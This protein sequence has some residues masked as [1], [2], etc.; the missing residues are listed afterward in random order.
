M[1]PAAAAGDRVSQSGGMW[2]AVLVAALVAFPVVAQEA[3]APARPEVPPETSLKPQ[4]RPADRAGT[5]D[6]DEPGRD[7]PLAA[8]QALAPETPPKPDR[9]AMGTAELAACL[10]ALDLLGVQYQTIAPIS[11]P[12]DAACG[13][14]QP[15]EVSALPGGVALEPAGQMR[16]E[17]ALALGQWVQDFVIPAA[18]R[19]PERGA[20][21]AIDQGSSY[22]CR[23]RNSQ[24]DGKLSEHAVGNGIDITGFRFASGAPIPI[25]PRE[26]DGGMAEA[27]QDTVRATACLHFTTVLGPGT[28]ATHSDHLHLDV[29]A[30]SSGFRLCQ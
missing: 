27:F 6:A 17:T 28:D 9:I 21:A 19:L 22:I 23:R 10:A 25:Q 3:D 8:G 15:V 29:I 20:L 26:R 7:A 13:I 18:E 24:P 4:A 5:P 11:E 14:R 12:E 1:P 2:G 30:R 16:C